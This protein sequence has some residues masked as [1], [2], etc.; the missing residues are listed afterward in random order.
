MDRIYIVKIKEIQK[1]SITRIP[2]KN[3]ERN[4][5][6]LYVMSRPQYEKKASCWMLERRRDI[7]IYTKDYNIYFYCSGI[8]QILEKEDNYTKNNI[9]L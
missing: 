9:P 3:N 4:G 6:M 1:T 2:G 5:N 7:I 8:N